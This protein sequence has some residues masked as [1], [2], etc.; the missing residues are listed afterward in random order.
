MKTV[1][2][3]QDNIIGGI[4]LVWESPATGGKVYHGVGN[5]ST[6]PKRMEAMERRGQ[7]VLYAVR[8]KPKYGYPVTFGV[9][10]NPVKIAGLVIYLR[11]EKTRDPITRKQKAP[12]TDYQRDVLAYYDE[13]GHIIAGRWPWYYSD[14]PSRKNKKIVLNGV[15]RSVVWLPDLEE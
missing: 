12:L 10:A 1:F 15:Q 3:H 4:T 14:K 8:I 7:K 9:T 2:S 13:A 5:R 11:R 6:L